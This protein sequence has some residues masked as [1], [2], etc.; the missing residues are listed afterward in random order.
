MTKQV[1]S[2]NFCNIANLEHPKLTTTK[3]EM[4]KNSRLKFSDTTTQVTGGL[5]LE[6]WA[7]RIELVT[8]IK[9]T[10]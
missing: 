3:Q 7:I 6:K 9:Y 4:T 5:Q 10:I 2:N 8:L 1:E